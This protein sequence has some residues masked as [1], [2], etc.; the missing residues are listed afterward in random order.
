MTATEQPIPLRE[1]GSTTLTFRTAEPNTFV[2][3]TYN[4]A[5]YVQ[6][7]SDFGGLG[8]VRVRITLD[9]L[10]PRPQPWSSTNNLCTAENT[11]TGYAAHSRQAGMRLRKAGR[12]TVQVFAIRDAPAYNAALYTS[13]ILVQD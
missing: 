12:H 6:S 9:G 11:R 1:D 3:V 8:T 5:C 7:Y 10:E 13:S 4:A 2:A